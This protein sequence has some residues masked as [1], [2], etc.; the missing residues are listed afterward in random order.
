M[1]PVAPEPAAPDAQPL[2]LLLAG[3]LLLAALTVLL[4]GGS[5]AWLDAEAQ[6]QPT[7]YRAPLTCPENRII[8]NDETPH[9]YWRAVYTGRPPTDPAC[10][11]GG[12]CFTGWGLLPAGGSWW[13]PMYQDDGAVVRRNLS[14]EVMEAGNAPLVVAVWPARPCGSSVW[15]PA[16]ERY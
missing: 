15:L 11:W 9:T 7:I 3:A 12:V 6:G 14:V 4:V 1:A 8:V 2:P 16:V 13:V 10:N 5:L